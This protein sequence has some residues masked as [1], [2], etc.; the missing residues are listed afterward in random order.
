MKTNEM[1]KCFIKRFI[2]EAIVALFI[3]CKLSTVSKSGKFRIEDLCYLKQ[4]AKLHLRAMLLHL[5]TSTLFFSTHQGNPPQKETWLI[6]LTPQQNTSQFTWDHHLTIKF[7]FQH[8][9]TFYNRELAS[10]GTTEMS[11]H[12]QPHLHTER[13]KRDPLTN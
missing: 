5:T 1:L 2:S 11:T 10:S 3:F 13:G 9:C 12:H 8:Y 6:T 4:G 7:C